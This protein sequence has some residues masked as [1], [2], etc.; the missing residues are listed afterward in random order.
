MDYEL[1]KCLNTV[2]IVIINIRP[3][4]PY[5]FTAEQKNGH[6]IN[7]ITL[8]FALPPFLTNICMHII[9]TCMYHIYHCLIFII[10]I[11]DIYYKVEHNLLPSYFDTLCLFNTESSKSYAKNKV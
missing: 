4:I 10:P 8:R 7:S 2:R 5:Y 6:T 11:N 9:S 3:I 1:I